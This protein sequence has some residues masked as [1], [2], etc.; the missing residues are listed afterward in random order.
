LAWE[1]RVATDLAE[2]WGETRRAAAGADLLASV[3]GR[4]TEGF[5]SADYLRAA[6]LKADLGRAPDSRRAPRTRAQC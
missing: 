4:F 5:A 3:L 6:R 2:L 1:L